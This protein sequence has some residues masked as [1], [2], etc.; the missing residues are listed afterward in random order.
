MIQI[1]IT[2]LTDANT[3]MCIVYRTKIAQLR[4]DM[5]VGITLTIS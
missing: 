5:Y 1:L 4:A 2:I 3:C